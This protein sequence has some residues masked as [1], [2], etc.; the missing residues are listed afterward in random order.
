MHPPQAAQSCRDPMA[1]GRVEERRASQAMSTWFCV[2][3]LP[4]TQ[5]LREHVFMLLFL[6]C[7]SPSRTLSIP[8][9]FVIWSF[10]AW[11]WWWVEDWISIVLIRLI[12]R[13]SPFSWV[14]GLW[15]SQFPWLFPIAVLDLN[16][17]LPKSRVLKKFFS[18]NLPP[19]RLNLLLSAAMSVYQ[20]A[21]TS[22]QWFCSIMEIEGK[23]HME[24]MALAPQW[25]LFSSLYLHHKGYFLGSF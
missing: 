24:F 13:H 12:P 16:L 19:L 4:L 11:L 17:L 18:F 20:H 23:T 15:F 9:L 1:E 22:R 5:C 8:R 2:F 6:S 21:N 14:L 25:L 7:L 10:L 3:G